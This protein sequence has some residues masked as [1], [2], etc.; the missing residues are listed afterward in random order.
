M[1]T[2]ATETLEEIIQRLVDA[3][4][5]LEIYLFGSHAYGAPGRDSDLDLLV[6][7]S[8]T[9]ESPRELARRGRQSLSG[10][11]FPVD[12]IVVT[13]SEMRKWS[14]V[15]CNIIHTVVQKGRRVYAA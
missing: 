1:E 9:D 15:R 6:V 8:D 3:L 11:G 5:P 7:V 4:H 13:L 14:T 2:L 12:I 10:M